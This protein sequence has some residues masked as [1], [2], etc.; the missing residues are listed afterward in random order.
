MLTL[1]A[2]APGELG[3]AEGDTRKALDTLLDRAPTLMGMVADRNARQNARRSDPANPVFPTGDGTGCGFAPDEAH[4]Y[5]L[6]MAFPEG[7]PMHPAYGAG[8]ATV[9]GA[10]VTV[11]KAFFEL[12]PNEVSKP[13]LG[14]PL[15]VEKTVEAQWWKQ[16]N[17]S[18][19]MKLRNVY[20]PPADPWASALDASGAFRPGALTIEG[21]L[22]KLAA[23]IALGR[24]MAGVHFYSDYYDSLRMG[25]RVAVGI[26]QE[27]M[28]GYK[29]PCSMRLPGFDGD[30]VVISTTG[31][32]DA[33]VQVL[34]GDADE[35]WNRHVPGNAFV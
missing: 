23:N 16:A 5:L 2:N 6:P 33:S 10:C 34:G 19:R 21:E 27:Q 24:N 4:N 14:Q 26:L 29:D 35:W 8:H 17:F 20:V 13:G 11:L 30:R 3:T 15:P 7:S 25:E 18:D 9:A 1:A 28:T 12:S 32:G 22:N 31:R